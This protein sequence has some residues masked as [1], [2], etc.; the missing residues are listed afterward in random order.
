ML[1]DSSKS[2]GFVRIQ[3]PFTFDGSA[4]SDADFSVVLDAH[5]LKGPC[6]VLL[7]NGP[8]Y[9]LSESFFRDMNFLSIVK[10]N[11]SFTVR[12]RDTHN[13]ARFPPIQFALE[14]RRCGAFHLFGH[15]RT[16]L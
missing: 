2:S 9:E 11:D 5:G 16:F 6:A 3:A 1:G 12:L 14:Q 15:G 7:I 4:N 8:V 10:M 13:G